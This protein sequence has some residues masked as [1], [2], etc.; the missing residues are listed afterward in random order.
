MY[1]GS[2]HFYGA[3]PEFFSMCQCRGPEFFHYV[4]QIFV[5]P[6][7]QCFPSFLIK[8]FCALVIGREE[9]RWWVFDT[10]MKG[11]NI[12]QFCLRRGP[13]FSSH[14]QRRGPVF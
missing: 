12:Y 13:E 3:G 5:V 6:L 1:L 9:G 11:A 14:S 2:Y 10:E 4:V 8:I 7:V